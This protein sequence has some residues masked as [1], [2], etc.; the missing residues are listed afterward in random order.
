MFIPILDNGHGKDTKGKRSPMGM[1]TKQN[2]TALFEYEF[3]RDIVK[4][5]AVLLDGACVPYH[6]LVPEIND[7]SLPERVVR[8][9]E[10]HAKDPAT[11]LV[12]VHANAGGGTGW[13]VWTS[14][15]KTESDVLATIFAKQAEQDFKGWRIRTDMSDGDVDKEAHFYILR[16]TRCPAVL[17][18][19]FFMDYPKDLEY[20]LS[21]KGRQDIAEMHAKA[22]IKIY[23]SYEVE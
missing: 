1:L 8:A 10:I 17:T 20:I 6:I 22:I 14:V 4:R 12:S 16:Y 23:E 15:G 9:N 3:N 5:I 7:I 11:Y 21:D 19:N 18:E 2:K 13:E